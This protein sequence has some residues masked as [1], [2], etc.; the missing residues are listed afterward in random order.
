MYEPKS[1]LRATAVV[2]GTA[3]SGGHAGRRIREPWTIR[4]KGYSEL[5]RLVR[6]ALVQFD[7]RTG[8]VHARGDGEIR[9]VSQAACPPGHFTCIHAVCLSAGVEVRY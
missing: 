5:D 4:E 3:R 6:D 7:S 8:V 1:P 2:I 9:S